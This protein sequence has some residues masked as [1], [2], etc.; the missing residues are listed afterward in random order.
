MKT[1]SKSM[2][3]ALGLVAA[4]LVADQV[5]VV[6]RVAI[7]RYLPSI[8]TIE[9]EVSKE[10]ELAQSKMNNKKLQLEAKIQE[11]ESS[12]DTISE[13]K[14]QK[15]RK[16]IHSLQRELK[17]LEAELREDLNLLQQET[18]AI[19]IAQATDIISQYAKDHKID[20]VLSAGPD[21]VVYA[22]DKKDITTAVIE[23][24][25]AQ[26]PKDKVADSDKKK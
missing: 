8:E 7:V 1:I 14:S 16:E 25:V 9:K 10:Y 22:P 18:N 4:P 13:Q 20:V 15:L 17:Y 24:L 19:L 2:L 5:A 12:K 6:D 23:T 3:L 21:V 11:Y 26:A